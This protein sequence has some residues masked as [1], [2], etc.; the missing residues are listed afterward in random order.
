MLGNINFLKDRLV[1]SQ[2]KTKRLFLIR[3]WVLVMGA[4]YSLLIFS[5]F[6]YHLLAKKRNQALKE[7]IKQKEAV[8]SNL[9]PIET[10]QVYLLS[11][12]ESLSKILVSKRQHQEV[13]G[14]LLSFLPEEISV[15]DFY[16]EE[17]G[18][19]TFSGSCLSFKVLKNFLGM[20]QTEG[21][22]SQLKVK[23]AKIENL[24][25]GGG[26]EYLFNMS[27]AFYLGE[28]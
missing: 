11:K 13:A 27:I 26:E 1:I 6:S 3:S 24:S 20:L 17:N 7:E 25:Y 4:I 21:R 2:K 9:R 5:S 22:D 28:E 12:I 19:I 23:E 8:I 15:S 14:A 10:K 18:T 16:I